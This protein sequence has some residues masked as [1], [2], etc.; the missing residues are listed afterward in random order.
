MKPGGPE[1]TGTRFNDCHY[2]LAL[3]RKAREKVL[4]TRAKN[5]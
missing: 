4:K 1:F 2:T 5:T 3:K